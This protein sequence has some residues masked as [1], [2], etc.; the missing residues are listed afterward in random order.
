MSPLAGRAIAALWTLFALAWLVAAS[1]AKRTLWRETIRSGL[2]HRLPLFATFALL[3]ARRALPPL[4]RLRLLPHSTALDALAIALTAAGVLF[5]IWARFH[6]GRN[7]SAAV[8]VKQ[9]HALVTSGP[10][11]FVRH[12]IYTGMLLAIL[13]TAIARASCA[14]SS[15]SSSPSPPSSTR[16]ASKK[17]ACARPFPRMR[18]MRR[19]RGRSYR[20]CY[21]VR[22]PERNRCPPT[23]TEPKGGISVLLRH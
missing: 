5:A 19:G 22:L 21:S 9:D 14:A 1:A 18:G 16:A 10:Y 2:T 15:P 4:L 6:L 20:S 23:R 17:P 3:G 7:W 8:T 11:R 12:P 13:G